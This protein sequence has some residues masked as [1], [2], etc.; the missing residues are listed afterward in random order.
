MKKCG[1]RRNKKIGGLCYNMQDIL[2][3]EKTTKRKR[4]KKKAIGI[5]AAVIVILGIIDSLHLY[6]FSYN[7][8]TSVMQCL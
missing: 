5:I 4:S 7:P 1:G 3:G 6:V 8:L 2:N